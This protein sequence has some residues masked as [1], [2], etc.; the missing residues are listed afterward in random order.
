MKTS[1]AIQILHKAISFFVK[2]TAIIKVFFRTL[3]KIILVYKIISCII[4]RINIDHLYFSKVCLL[5]Q[6]QYFQI[7]SLDI[8]I[9]CMI[10]INTFL[11]TRTKCLVNR[12]ICQKNRLLLIRPGKLITFLIPLNHLCINFL[13][14]H[15]FI[16]RT[17]HFPGCWINGFC[18]SIWK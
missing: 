14:Q 8:K 9:L 11:P 2:L 10:K 16:N 15:I 17:N 5:K 13:H 18:H 6:F 7:I 12:R 1:I 4:R 3:S